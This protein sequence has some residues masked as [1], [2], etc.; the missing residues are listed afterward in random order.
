MFLFFGIMCFYCYMGVTIS[1]LI[2]VVFFELGSNSKHT[3]LEIP[4]RINMK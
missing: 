3:K 4:G 2:I 1:E